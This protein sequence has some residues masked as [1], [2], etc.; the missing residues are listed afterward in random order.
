M[1][2]KIYELTSSQSSIWNTE[3]FYNGSNINNICG[4]INLF[5]PLNFDEIKQTLQLIIDENDNFHTHFLIKDG[6]VYQTFIDNID[7]EIEIVEIKTQEDLKKLEEKMMSHIFDILNSSL[8]E[9]KIFKYPN[10]TGGVIVNIHHLISDSWTLGL[11][12]KN[13][14]SKYY[15]LHNKLPIEPKINSY[16]NY[17]NSENKYLNSSKFE[18]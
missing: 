4:T 13:I 6:T 16:V 9:F 1:D 8:F 15:N 12:A 10:N 2:G 17:I 5:E 3:L 11:I 18:I 14:V 7:Y